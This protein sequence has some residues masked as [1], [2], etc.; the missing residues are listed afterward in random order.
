MSGFFKAC[1]EPFAGDE[2]GGPSNL[3]VTESSLAEIV[4]QLPAG[5]RARREYEDLIAGKIGFD[6]EI[7]AP[8]SQVWSA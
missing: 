1:L 5:H 7:P 8:A 4:A 3:P 2:T 6:P